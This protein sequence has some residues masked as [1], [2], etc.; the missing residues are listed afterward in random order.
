MVAKQYLH[1]CCEPLELVE[2][3]A[4]PVDRQKKMN[5]SD[6]DCEGMCGV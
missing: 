4:K 2:L 3:N 5:F 1:R 6:M